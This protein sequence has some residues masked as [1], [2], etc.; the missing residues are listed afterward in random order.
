MSKTR[1][2][3]LIMLALAVG[4]A[5]PPA[6]A[7]D[8]PRPIRALLISGGCCHDY[9][10]Q[11]K[12][13]PEG[14]S[15]R[16]RVE[17]TVVQEGGTSSDHKVSLYEIPGWADHYDVVVHNECFGA[18]GDKAFIE[19]AIAPHKQGVP[20]VVIHCSMHNFR[21]LK[22]DE[23]REFLGV[24]TRAHGPQQPL[25]VKNLMP[26][27]PVMKGFPAVWTTGKEEL[28]AILKVW[29]GTTTLAQAYALDNKKDHP[30]I[31][32]HETDKS[33]VFG[34]TIAH[35]NATMSDPVYLDMLT[36]GLLW[37]CN[38]L[39]DDGKPKPGYEAAPKAG[40]ASAS[41]APAK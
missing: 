15:A 1:V 37:S 28:Y 10:A 11:D 3:T 24:T 23:W 5:A 17:W 19:K 41:P 12:I 9:K 14:V 29:P 2:P 8:P 26:E 30:V 38:K 39:D 21:E 27:H 36:R 20:A 7:A 32:T 25:E 22:S 16:A 35:N 4:P 33:R 40:G 6:T 13:I 31:W 18:V 34:T